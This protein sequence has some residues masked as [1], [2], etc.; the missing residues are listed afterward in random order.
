[1]LQVGCVG[2]VGDLDIDFV[3]ASSRVFSILWKSCARAKAAAKKLASVDYA[4]PDDVRKRARAR[5]AATHRA[6]LTR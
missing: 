3:I 2:V 5:T 6:K 1:M 4:V